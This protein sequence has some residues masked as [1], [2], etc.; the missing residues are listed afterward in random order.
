[1]ATPIQ[2]KL[3]L[4]GWAISPAGIGSVA[5]ELSGHG[6]FTA[7]YGRRRPDVHKAFYPAPWARRAGFVAEIPTNGW[8]P[9]CFDVKVIA[10]DLDGR[11]TSHDGRITWTPD[12]RELALASAQGRPALWVGEPICDTSHPLSE[13]VSVRGWVSAQQPVESVVVELEGLE[14]AE[15][16]V[17]ERQ[18]EPQDSLP[19]AGFAIV[20]DARGTERAECRLTVRATTRDGS[21]TQRAGTI[22][23]DP[24]ARHRRRARRSPA[25]GV[26]PLDDTSDRAEAHVLVAGGEP[27]DALLA[28]LAA[29]DQPPAAVVTL[30]NGVGRALARLLEAPNRFGVFAA[31]TDSFAPDALSKLAGAFD[32]GSPAD[33]V[34]SDH[35]AVDADG[36]GRMR[37]LKPGWSP[38]LF[39]SHPYVGSVFAIGP[40]AA[41][42]ALRRDAPL[43]S[44]HALLLELADEPL[45]VVRIPEALWSRAPGEFAEVAKR[46]DAALHDLAERRGA[47]LS[48]TARD[49]RRGTRSVEWIVDDP[50]SVTVVIP[51]TGREQ[52]LGSCLRSL[53]ERTNYERLDVVLVDTGGDAAATADAAGI[54]ATIAPYDGAYFNFSR[55]CNIGL[56]HARGDL[57]A[58]LNDDVEALDP[59]WLSRMVS[60]AQLPASGVVGAKLIYPGGLIQHTGLF[61]ARLSGAPNAN[62]AAAQ[63]AFHQDSDDM[64]RLMNLPRDCS[65]VTGACMLMSRDVLGELGGWD[66]R[67][68]IDFGDIDLCLRAI[69]HGRRALVEPR[70]RLLHRVHSTQGTQPHD[71]DDGRRLTDR[72]SA[73]YG[74]GDPWHHPSCRFGRDWELA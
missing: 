45:D 54:R 4:E 74:N 19:K 62:L 15:A 36:N 73:A 57:V 70:A 3:R 33:L 41:E 17:A 10:E 1:M 2:G 24:V 20:L 44:P 18:Y 35:D 66:E 42:A 51:T 68:R 11:S 67:F 21:S 48:I 69:E 25:S 40:R 32:G 30:H 53:V 13:E 22:L 39:L 63:F 52:P 58:F 56:D 49:P 64:G 65:A 72:W 43:H 50:P 8:L 29:Q 27:Q 12:Q 26:R 38:E 59:S 9:S 46:E 60:H 71:E 34:Y 6:S 28:S 37:V 55:A 31:P 7:E 5:V 14:P 47:R 61:L 16:F 23:I